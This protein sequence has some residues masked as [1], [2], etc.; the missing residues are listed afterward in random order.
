MRKYFYFY[1]HFLLMNSIEEAT[2][3]IGSTLNLDSEE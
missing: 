2:L 3:R 1:F